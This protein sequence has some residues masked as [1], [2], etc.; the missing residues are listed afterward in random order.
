MKNSLIFLFLFSYLQ[1][2]HGKNLCQGFIPEND[3]KIYPGNFNA[4]IS[5]VEF[6]S[7]LDHF[8]K[9]YSPIIKKEGG[10]LLLSRLWKEATV[11]ASAQRFGNTWMLNMFGGLA[12]HPLMT[13]DGFRLVL[14]HELA[15]HLGGSPKIGGM[16]GYW[17]SVEGQA[18]YFAS[19]KCFKRMVDGED[20]SIVIQDQELPTI[21]S[22]ACERSFI[23][24]DEVLLCLRGGLAGLKL[25][26]FMNSLKENQKPISL[27]TP[28]LSVVKKTLKTHPEV[29]CRLDTY[30]R[31]NICPLS[32]D[33]EIN[34]KN[35]ELGFCTTKNQLEYGSRPRCWYKP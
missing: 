30:F 31:A 8:E 23:T 27:D 19:M 11:N 21:L 18:D 15:H 10:V 9:I 35:E 16:R 29:Q 22:N 12:R 34:Q 14:C 33:V 4:G 17:A 7:V 3:L 6:H 2:S 26:E 28:D 20:H 13:I 1:V 25:A 24:K 32:F 5:E